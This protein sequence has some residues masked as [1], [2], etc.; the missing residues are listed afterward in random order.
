M[1]TLFIA[2]LSAW[3]VSSRIC[4][5][6]DIRNSVEKLEL[7]RGCRVVE[8]H[9]HIVLMERPEEADFRNV[10]LPELRE[11]TDYLMF[12]RVM[13]I[14]SVGQL[15]PNLTLIRGHT[16]F[17]DYALVLYEVFDL[18]EVALTSLARVTRGAVRIEK[19]PSLCYVNTVNWDLIAKWD[20][21]KNYVAK[22]K[23][24]TDCPGCQSN[25][26]EGL[27]W[28]GSECQIQPE[29]HCHP[30]CLGGCSGPGPRDCNS[31][32]R[33]V[34]VDNECVEHCPLGTY[35]HLNRRC[36]TREECTSIDLPSGASRGLRYHSSSGR[37]AKKY[38]IFN[39]TCI[40]S[41]PPG[42][43]IDA[44]GTG[45]TLC[46]G[47]K[48][49]KWCAG[50][51]IE[52]IAAAQILRGC[53]HIEGSLEISI[54]TGKPKIIFE[55]LEENLG[56]I[57]EIE[58]YLKIVRSIPIV[59]LKFLR[60]LTTIRGIHPLPVGYTGGGDNYTLI[61]IENQNI[62][63]LW[64]LDSKPNFKILNG[65]V[66]FHHNPKLCLQHIH[67]FL[68]VIHYDK[69]VT[70][71]E[72]GTDSN[73]DKFP[74]N[75]TEIDVTVTYKSPHIIQINIPFLKISYDTSDLRYV[76]YYTPDPNGNMTMFDDFDQCSEHHW[77][78]KDVSV[79]PSDNDFIK[80]GLQVNLTHLEPNTQY[81]LYVTTYTIDRFG[82]KSAMLYET[83]LPSVPSE[84]TQLVGFSNENSDI[85]LKWEGPK[86]VNGKMKEYIV[87]WSL[88]R[89]DE[90]RIRL[91]NYCDHPISYI[92]KNEAT[93]PIIP[94]VAGIENECCAES[95]KRPQITKDGF[96]G[97]CSD[98]NHY[99][100]PTGC[101]NSP[102]AC[103]S[104]FYSYVYSQPFEPI[105]HG[106]ERERLNKTKIMLATNKHSDIGDERP[107][108]MRVHVPGNSS[109]YTITNVLHYQDYLVTVRACREAHPDELNRSEDSRCSRTDIVTVR[110]RKRELADT[111][112]SVSYK[113][114]NNTVLLAW[115]VPSKPN[116]MIVGFETEY[117]HADTDN[118]NS[119]TNCFTFSEY[120]SDNGILLV[121]L[122]PGGYEFRVRAISLAGR[123]PYTNY[124]YFEIANRS[125]SVFTI[126]L[127]FA[128]LSIAIIIVTVSCTIYQK[129]KH[130]PIEKL[131]TSA[132]P[133]Y[134]YV[135][136]H[137]EIPREDVEIIR[138]LGTGSFGK[139]YEGILKSKNIPCAI[140]TVHED[141]S[142]YDT[143][144][145]LSEASV[146]KSVSA[147]YHIVHLLG[148][149]S[150]ARPPLVLMELMSLGD[151]KTYLRSTRETRSPS[152]ASMIRMSLQIGDGMTFMETMK[153]VHR[154]LAARNCMVNQDGIVKV[155]DFGMTRD[156]YETD[157]YRK[158]NTGLLPI[159]WMAP[160]S[161]KDGVFTS[162]SDV[163]SFGVVLWEIVT[164]AEQP[165][166]GSSNDQVLHDVIAGRKL[167]IPKH[168]P[169]VLKN[170]MISCWRRKPSQRMTFMQ[171]LHSLEYYHDEDFKKISY[172]YSQ[173]A[174]GLRKA[175]NDYVEMRSVEDPLL[176]LAQRS[177]DYQKPGG[178]SLLLS[179]VRSLGKTERLSKIDE[180]GPSFDC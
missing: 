98:Y 161:L 39:G 119:I 129:K 149:V 74:C 22:N 125:F 153:F 108:A 64:D 31:C 55:E 101:Y 120:Q 92:S 96:E 177:A 112:S 162:Q 131:F 104:C 75:A 156:V 60:N 180:S 29:S 145:F 51:N 2:L 38:I 19:N 73:G 133:D 84:L 40:D 85:V 14:Q 170:I 47:G 65:K 154:D 158:N 118:I 172:Y 179:K 63:E 175:S 33:L 56:S 140:K 134:Q 135:Q 16:L 115:E 111:I 152:T 87:T 21:L 41:C 151:L 28:S 83:T 106:M 25:C 11:I 27:C 130:R 1:I 163:W 6:V 3:R 32:Q 35:Q 155:G 46:A 102:L 94:Q 59:S 160:E 12:Y 143:N 49:Q 24:A 72:V 9:V 103:E 76:I 168:S 43:E 159:R 137:W 176:G 113:V 121:G 68:S 110:T 8:G 45:C 86:K 132:N 142:A 95:N 126:L 105:Y 52:N 82:A 88:L 138:E 171:I 44:A 61:V 91:R 71:L 37:A 70:N 107:R 30:L 53:T 10:S 18:S 36:I 124:I 34:T 123:G 144:I 164:L 78:T 100:F 79:D 174:M 58:F 122:V 20:T 67:K 178:V 99:Q 69:N 57:E 127:V 128:T 7:L 167:N 66:F 150:T 62:Q 109:G 48:C 146:M 54:K 117:H 4:P 77:T 15:F 169:E 90:S 89:Y 80:R 93:E 5:S 139:V 13:G 114:V 97:L 147:A 17:A 116:G 141:A 50:Q 157:Y 148:V 81:A 165:Y 26:P 173:E 23:D 136:D 166:Q 42:Y